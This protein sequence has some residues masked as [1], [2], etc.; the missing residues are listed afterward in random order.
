MGLKPYVA[1]MLCGSLVAVVG[2]L[3]SY[4]CES[5]NQSLRL[6]FQPVFLIS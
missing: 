2:E 1:I 6:I 5:N 4:S 3:E